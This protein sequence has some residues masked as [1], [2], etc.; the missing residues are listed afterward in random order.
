MVGLDS[1]LN[2]RYK[3][4][5]K[6]GQGGFAEVYLA[7]D[8]T[9]K[10]RVAVKV[11][12]ANLFED[13]SFLKRFENEAQA[14]AALEHPNIL[15]VY[16]YGQTDNTVY[17]IMPFVE[18]G[19]LHD[20]LRRQKKFNLQTAS[21][22]LQ[23]IA[24]ALDYAHRRNIVHRDVKPHNVLIREEDNRLFLADFGIAKVLSAATTN[25]N[26]NVVGTIAYMAPEQ[27]DGKAG[28]ETDVYALGC[29]LF[30]MI[31]GELPYTGTTEQVMV[32]HMMKPV[33][34][35]S[36]R[37][38][39][40]L[41]VTLQPIFDKALAKERSY[42]YKS[43]G[44]LAKEFENLVNELIH[45]Q[46]FALPNV[47]TKPVLP[48]NAPVT[49]SA[50]PV[51]PLSA[52]ESTTPI[53][54]PNTPNFTPNITPLQP[55]EISPIA[56]PVPPLADNPAPQPPV[57]PPQMS[58]PVLPGQSFVVAPPDMVSEPAAVAQTVKKPAKL[59]LPAIIGSGVAVVAI[60]IA[61][62]SLIS[63]GGSSGSRN[64]PAPN[65]A[66]VSGEDKAALVLRGNTMAVFGAAFSPDG[67]TLATAG[68][69]SSIRLWDVET[70]AQK[71]SWGPAHF[72]GNQRGAVHTVVYSP[73]GKLIASG[74]SDSH[75][76]IWDATTGMQ[77]RTITGHTNDVNT[78]VFSKSGNFL[79]S[80]AYDSTLRQWSLADGREVSIINTDS[81]VWRV[82]LSPDETK[83]AA[84]LDNSKTFVF[85]IENNLLTAATVANSD[86]ESGGGH[87]SG[88]AFSPDGKL[89]LIANDNQGNR[90]LDLTT[91][92][93]NDQFFSGAAVKDKA[94]AFSKDGKTVISAGSEPNNALLFWDASN[95]KLLRKLEGHEN[96][97]NFLTV[98]PTQNIVATVSED[99]TIRIWKF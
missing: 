57:T 51:A 73:D 88:V 48:E 72:T 26:T 75:I 54:R 34:S 27:L 6:V 83:I 25:S 38:E 39:G 65:T 47:N 95:G 40:Q 35:I 96:G 58:P 56:V 99:T 74:G 86:Y 29:V 78:L 77:I 32:G 17:L 44:E 21:Q 41:P 15:P 64:T 19:T 89:V 37:S 31:S 63:L 70:G 1:V 94:I 23:Q 69:D 98:H 97:I 60:V 76:R 46:T 81:G 79:Y 36:E 92:K 93:T 42:R 80:G 30:Q 2:G 45:L 68:L 84:A 90:V 7:T 33:P 8:Q 18:G 59:P 50:A 85:K 11:L 66:P 13:E 91:Q 24:S 10:R 43:A 4:D 61:L 12:N 28:F 62:I 49:L 14:V 52:P 87:D 67:K 20:R 9:L 55:V 5:K 82:A 22:Y 53:E 3:L 71:T 16:D